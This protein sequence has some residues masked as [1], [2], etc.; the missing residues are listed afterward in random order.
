[1]LLKNALVLVSNRKVQSLFNVGPTF[2]CVEDASVSR[3]LML[4]GRLV[5]VTP[6]S[7]QNIV[8]GK[9]LPTHEPS[10]CQLRTI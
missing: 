1:M 4:V 8:D 9:M 2:V 5:L 7:E 3:I 6:G 10:I